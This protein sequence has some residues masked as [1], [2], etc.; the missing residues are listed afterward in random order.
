MNPQRRSNNK[1]KVS[2]PSR[3]RSHSSGSS[4]S[5]DS[6]NNLFSTPSSSDSGSSSMTSV[7]SQPKKKRSVMVSDTTDSSADSSTTASSSRARSSSKSST[8]ASGSIPLKFTPQRSVPAFLN[9]L[10]NMVEDEST[11]NLI[12]WSEDGTSF[13]VEDHEE[14]AK[15]VLPR[16]YKHNTFASFVRQLNMYDFHKVPHL[17]QCVLI[18]ENDHE[19][20]EFSNPHFRQGRPDLLT[21]VTRK[22]NRDKDTVDTE[23]VSLSTLVTDLSLLKKHQATIGSDLHDL[24]RD[25]EILWQETLNAREKYQRHQDAIEK[26]IQFLTTIFSNEHPAISMNEPDALPKG[27][28]EEAAT[29]AGIGKGSDNC[30]SGQPIGSQSLYNGNDRSEEMIPKAEPVVDFSRTLNS[31]SKSAQTI[32]EDIDMLQVNI[33]SLANNLGIDPAQFNGNLD[34]FTG[35]FQD[36]YNSMISSANSDDKAK[37]FALAGGNNTAP[38]EFS[39]SRDE[40]SPININPLQQPPASQSQFILQSRQTPSSNLKQQPMYEASNGPTVSSRNG[41][42]VNNEQIQHRNSY[43]MLN[44][45]NRPA[46][47][48]PNNIEIPTETAANEPSYQNMMPMN[49]QE[50]FSPTFSRNGDTP[51]YAPRSLSFSYDMNQPPPPPPPQELVMNM[52]P[53]VNY[54]SSNGEP[55]TLGMATSTI[56]LDTRSTYNT[57]STYDESYPT[58]EEGNCDVPS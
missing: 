5:P 51:Y 45:F 8:R 35:N 33:E 25:N 16:F 32:S 17:Q 30:K 10:Y 44:M 28:I 50:S 34:A 11:S 6:S 3:K 15:T 21:L 23:D 14:F 49:I 20:W 38:K 41:A 31:A 22:R 24:R 39:Y 26:I 27:L 9:K 4:S 55:K 52:Q 19:I 37:L 48:L 12:R 1:N 57:M 53:P 13:L 47:P 54:Y 56:P 7:R 2:P 29:L 40:Q 18:A 42:T 58:F 46:Q 43:P 36:S